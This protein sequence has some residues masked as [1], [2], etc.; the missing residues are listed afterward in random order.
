MDRYQS[1]NSPLRKPE[2]KPES[3]LYPEEPAK[4]DGCLVGGCLEFLAVLVLIA[5]MAVIAMLFLGG[6]LGHLLSVLQAGPSPSPALSPAAS[7]NLPLPSLR[8]LLP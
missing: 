6:G 8:S 3:D 1:Q 4:S 2:P 5:I 7:G